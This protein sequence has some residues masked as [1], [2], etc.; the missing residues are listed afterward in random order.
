MKFSIF[1]NN[2][3][4]L[5]EFV[6]KTDYSALSIQKKAYNENILIDIP[7]GDTTDSLILLAFTEKRNKNEIDKLTDFFQNVC[8]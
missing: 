7:K 2:L 6:V 8:I 5:K 1:N 3:M 4:F